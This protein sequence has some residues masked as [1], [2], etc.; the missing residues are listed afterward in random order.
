MTNVGTIGERPRKRRTWV[1]RLDRR[2]YPGRTRNWDDERFR[3]EILAHLTPATRLLDLGAGAGIVQ[4]MSFRGSCGHVIGVDPDPRVHDNPHLDEAHVG[5]G[6]ALPCPDASVDVV[7]ADNVLE[8]LDE[9]ER[10]FAEVARVLRPGG[11][12]LA[13]TPNRWHYMPV[14]AQLTPTAFHRFVNR[15]RGRAGEDTFP[16]RYR[17]NSAR[18]LRRLARESG[19]RLRK[20]SRIEDRPEY[21][22]FHPLAYLLG[23]A[24]ERAVNGL[25]WL[26][27][28]RV[29]LIAEFERNS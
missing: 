22:R 13:K 28:F 14:L 15:R 7:V 10:V 12:F 26:A 17:A 6:E 3:A 4:A 5:V 18:A 2:L 1:E 27:P 9:P 16:T 20:L 23:W 21:L 24:W 25:R 8:H 29:L 19:F 11:T